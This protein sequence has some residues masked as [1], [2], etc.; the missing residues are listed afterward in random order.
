MAETTISE[1]KQAV[2]ERVWTELEAS[3]AAEPG[4]HGNIPAFARAEAAAM[5]L[6]GRAEWA[7]AV[8]KAVPDRA[9]LPVRVQ[10]LSE[11]KLV[12]MAV[13]KMADVEPFYVLDPATLTAPFEQVA[14]GRGRPQRLPGSEPATCGRSTSSSA[15]ASQSTEPEPASERCRLL[16]HRGRPPSRGGPTTTG[17]RSSPRSTRYRSSRMKSPR[18]TTTSRRFHRHARRGH[19]V[20]PTPPA[21]RHPLGSPRSARSRRSRP[22]KPQPAAKSTDRAS[23]LRDRDDGLTDVPS[24]SRPRRSGWPRPGCGA[25]PRRRCSRRPRWPGPRS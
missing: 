21:Q 4:V 17:L 5:R 14:T 6:A 16:R 13:P 10:A 11:G 2:R 20:Q 7:A 3:G 22:R 23:G 8:L 15:A 25:R 1:A 9:Q 24:V 12:Y 19:R 18:P